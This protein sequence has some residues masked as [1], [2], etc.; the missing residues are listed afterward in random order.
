MELH[1]FVYLINYQLK[2]N[3]VVHES[4]QSET[5]IDCLLPPNA[6]AM[7]AML[8]GFFEDILYYILCYVFYYAISS[9]I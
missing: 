4:E 7:I 8:F 6:T 2:K 1:Y 5:L 9:H 3:G